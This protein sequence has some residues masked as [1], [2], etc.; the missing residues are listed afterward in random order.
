LNASALAALA[1]AV[2]MMAED[3]ETRAIIAALAAAA[4]LMQRSIIWR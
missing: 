2:G 1:A 4:E 3:Q